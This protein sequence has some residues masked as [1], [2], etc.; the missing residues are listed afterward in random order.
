MSRPSTGD[1]PEYFGRYIS[2]V[3]EDDLMEA[4][5]NQDNVF[6][7]LLK[8]IDESKANYSYAEGK[9]TIKELLQ[10]LIDAERIFNYRALAISRK[11][12]LSL[13][14]FDENLYAG[15]SRGNNRNWN[16]LVNEFLH[17][18]VST[19]DLYRS[20]TNDMLATKGLADN[21]GITVASLGFITIGHIIHHAGILK[22]R[23]HI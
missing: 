5:D 4:F 2:K 1:Y 10:H 23:Y 13:P 14:S 20:F 21:K 8:S 15:N 22:E 16:D 3:S 12:T 6:E 7:S 11:E 18:R 19:K 9:W 17:L